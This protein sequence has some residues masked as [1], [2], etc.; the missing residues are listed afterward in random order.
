MASS[1]VWF[2]ARACVAGLAL[3]GVAGM[4]AG[5]GV[6]GAAATGGPLRG[7]PAGRHFNTGATHS[8]QLLRQLAGPG[9]TAPGAVL[10]GAKRGVDVADYQE[11]YGINW[12]KVAAAGIQFAASKPPKATT[13]A[14]PTR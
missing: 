9:T 14:T 4:V 1:R 7:A 2:V 8:P 13:T 3:A 11:R 6:A 10:T 12:S 5:A